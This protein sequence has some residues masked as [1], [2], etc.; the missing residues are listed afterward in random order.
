MVQNYTKKPV[1]IQAIKWDN[2]PEIADDVLRFVPADILD[3]RGSE[4]RLK[5]LE[6]D[7]TVSNGDYIIKG[8]KG[9]FYPCKPDIF[10]MTYIEEKN[11]GRS[12]SWA[13]D[14]IKAGYRVCRKGWNGKGMWLKLHTPNYDVVGE[15]ALLPW[16]GMKTADDCFVPWLCS[17]TDAL[18]EDWELVD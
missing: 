4:L 10:E 14:M 3:I 17:Q 15:Y 1:T 9:E 7:M 18:C 12:Y 6:G 13:L 2:T 16:I 5:T 8:V 11:Y